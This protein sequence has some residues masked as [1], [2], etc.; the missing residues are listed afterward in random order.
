[1]FS[2]ELLLG[3]V[4][5]ISMLLGFFASLLGFATVTLIERYLERRKKHG[6]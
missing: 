1:M 5:M 6:K 3:I 4:I 2:S